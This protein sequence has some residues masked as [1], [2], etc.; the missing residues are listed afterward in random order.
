MK[1]YLDILKTKKFWTTSYLLLGVFLSLLQTFSAS[2]FQK[3]L[4][5]FGNHQLSRQTIIVYAL[6][7]LSICGLNYFDEYPSTKL[8]ESIY[9]DFKLKA[10]NKISLIDYSTYQ[11]LGTGNLIQKIESGALA[12]KAILFDFYFQLLRDLIPSVFF[13]LIFIM[14]INKNILFYIL[15]GYLLIFVITNILLKYL[16]HIKSHIL[17]NE[18]LFNKY[19]IRSFMELV[20]FRLHKKFPQETKKATHAAEQIIASKIHMKLIHE[21]FFALFACFII[22]IK[23]IILF[24]S[25]KKQSLSVG[26]LVALLALIDKAYSP[27]AIFN[28]LFVQYKLDTSTFQRYTDF[29]EMPNDSNLTSGNK[30][31]ILD[32]QID[33]ENIDFSYLETNIFKQLSFKINAGSSVALVGESGSGKSTIVKLIIGL[34]KPK[35]GTILIDGS[36]LSNLN[37]HDLYNHISYTSQ[38]SPIFNGTLRENII[39][40]RMITDQEILAALESV[41]LLSFYSKLPHGLDTEVGERGMT[42]SGGEKQRIALARL[43]FTNAKIIILDEAT[44][45]MDNIIEERVVQH[46]MHYLKNKTII[47]IAHRLNTIKNVEN[48]FVFKSGEIVESGRFDELLEKDSYFKE[49]WNASTEK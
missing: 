1:H 46:L 9:L 10:M 38:E 17:N 6:I 8:S 24:V 13:S 2:Y 34:L 28:V 30:I 4:D 21:A 26:S 40:D 25:W 33:F 29:L 20:V 32:G 31:A 43:Y 18:E 22:V 5:D 39:F 27:I 11:T 44:S 37:L 48:I 12:G 36:N 42:L 49:L 35:S 15:I 23:I 14:A 7:L 41:E 47:S 3:V 19:L 45:A 16:Y